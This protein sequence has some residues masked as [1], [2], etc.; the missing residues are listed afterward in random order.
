M[1]CTKREKEQKDIFV[2]EKESDFIHKTTPRLR[3]NSNEI[4]GPCTQQET[5]NSIQ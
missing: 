5:P 2:K 4:N 1:C 3:R